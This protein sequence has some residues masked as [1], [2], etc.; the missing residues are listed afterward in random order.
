MFQ[1]TSHAEGQSCLNANWLQL[2]PKG[3]RYNIGC[4][5]WP[6]AGL[7]PLACLMESICVQPEGLPVKIHNCCQI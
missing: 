7:Y 1:D 3:L 4:G 6:G 2:L 5:T